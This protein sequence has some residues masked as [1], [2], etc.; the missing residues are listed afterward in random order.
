MAECLPNMYQALGL[1]T[2]TTSLYFQFLMDQEHSRMIFYVDVSTF[3][4]RKVTAVQYEAKHGARQRGSGITVILDYIDSLRSMR[5]IPDP[6]LKKKKT[7][8]NKS[9]SLDAS[10]S[11]KWTQ[12]SSFSTSILNDL[13]DRRKVYGAKHP[14]SLISLLCLRKE[15]PS[16]T[17]TID[18]TEYKGWAAQPRGLPSRHWCPPSI[19]WICCCFSD[20]FLLLYLRLTLEPGSPAGRVRDEQRQQWSFVSQSCDQWG[21]DTWWEAVDLANEKSHWVTGNLLWLPTHT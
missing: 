16:S 9:H 11:K 20:W 13:Y 7:R 21:H 18:R 2:S 3:A 1:N 12:L 17:P 4:S 5:T 19:R 15:A 6:I 8:E 14:N 10:S